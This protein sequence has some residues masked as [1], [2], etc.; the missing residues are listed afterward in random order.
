MTHPALTPE[1]RAR[2]DFMV[3]HNRTDRTMY[4]WLM[5]KCGMTRHDAHLAIDHYVYGEPITCEP[6]E[7]VAAQANR[8]RDL[9]S[10]CAK[11]RDIVN[12][13]APSYVRTELEAAGQAN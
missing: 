4:A 5:D 7:I 2:I 1:Q 8:I 12:T 10:E 3:D 6:A 13:Y 9:V 11:L